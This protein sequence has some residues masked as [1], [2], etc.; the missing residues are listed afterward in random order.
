MEAKKAKAA[1]VRKKKEAENAAADA[2]KKIESESAR[3]I[4][5]V[6][7]PRPKK[8]AE[9]VLVKVAY[10]N[11]RSLGD[12]CNRSLKLD[13]LASLEI[14]P[15]VLLL[16]E[17]KMKTKLELNDSLTF[18]TNLSGKGGAAALHTSPNARKIKALN[19]NILWSTDRHEGA[20]VH[21]VTVYTPP[22][23][24]EMADI[25]LRQLSWILT[26]IFFID[27]DSLV[28]VAG[29][30]NKVGM[31]KS[32]FLENHFRLTPVIPKGYPTHKLGGH[33]DNVW[34]NISTTDV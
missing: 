26:R 14:N 32:D 33:L 16:S 3:V 7:L 15:Q 9:Q 24:S 12:G 11:I 22:N 4:G 28:V 1:E 31:K 17:T 10:W 13:S 25:T 5:H 19:E 8:K 6:I 21:Y 2:K 30:L 18:Q 34:T 20:L 29:D 23:D 27:K